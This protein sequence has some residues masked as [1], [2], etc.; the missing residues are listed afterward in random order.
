LREES[1]SIAGQGCLLTAGEGDF[2]ESEQKYTADLFC[3]VGMARQELTAEEATSLASQT[4]P[5]ARL[6]YK[7][8]LMR[9]LPVRLYP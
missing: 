6:G 3:K 4:P 5:D 2:K 7:L 9:G 1:P 8:A